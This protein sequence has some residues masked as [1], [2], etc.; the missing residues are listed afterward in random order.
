[1]VL[2]FYIF[3]PVLIYTI[4]KSICTIQNDIKE[5]GSVI[6]PAWSINKI[7]WIKENEPEIYKN[8][9]KFVLYEDFIMQKFG[10]EPTISYSLAGLTMA[11]DSKDKKWSETLRELNKHLKENLKEN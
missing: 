1:M 5:T 9:W 8:T 7:M 6:A 2:N 10:L 4:L 11:F 3:S